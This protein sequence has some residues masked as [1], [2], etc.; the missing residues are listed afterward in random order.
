[1]DRIITAKHNSP[2]DPLDEALSPFGDAIAEAEGWLDGEPV[3]TEGQMR[4]VDALLAQVKAAEK[5]VAAA[6]ESETKPLYDTWK[7]AKAR[8]KPT[9]D[10]LARIRKGLIAAVDGYKR[11]L[12]AEKEAARIEAERQA[13][14]AADAAREAV[15][16]AENAAD[17]EAQR[18]A[19][20]TQE[21]FEIAR[22]KAKRAATDTV[23]GMRQHAVVVIDD[24]QT[25]ARWIWLNDMPEM[26]A[27]LQRYAETHTGEFPGVTK[28]TER[29]AV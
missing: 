11:K 13:W 16:A 24:V 9:H 7:A 12:A 2:P 28:S 8:F 17:I 3:S 23:R 15:Q 1:M 5:A 6:D 18:H 26:R 21:A 22:A 25:F 19:A 20:A 14:A 10:D 29:R 27:F 4:A